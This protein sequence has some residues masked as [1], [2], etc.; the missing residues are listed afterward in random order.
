MDT[1]RPKSGHRPTALVLLGIIVVTGH[2]QQGM[3]A[4]EFTVQP[5]GAT[6]CH[7]ASS[8]PALLWRRC[9]TA[10]L[11][12]PGLLFSGMCLLDFNPLEPLKWSPLILGLDEARLLNYYMVKLNTSCMGDKNSK[13]QSFGNVINS[14]RETRSSPHED[15]SNYPSLGIASSSH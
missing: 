9:R 10:V 8:E 3:C 1:F 5:N 12:I 13:G 2:A 6:S 14:Y 4:L 15:A 11:R 7:F